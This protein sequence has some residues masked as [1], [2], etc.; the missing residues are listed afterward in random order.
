MLINVIS[1]FLFHSFYSWD[2][3]L[4]LLWGLFGLRL[5]VG[6]GEFRVGNLSFLSLSFLFC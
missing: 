4:A 3:I 1:S 6:G 5:E 2:M